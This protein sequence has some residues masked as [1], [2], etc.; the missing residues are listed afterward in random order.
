MVSLFF[1]LPYSPP[2]FFSFLSIQFEIA[3]VSHNLAIFIA[4]DYRI[5]LN[6]PQLHQLHQLT[7]SITYFLFLARLLH[8]RQQR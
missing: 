2:L 8:F 3:T 4:K 5:T 6:Y 7:Y 1:S